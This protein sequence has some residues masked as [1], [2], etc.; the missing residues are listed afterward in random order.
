MQLLLASGMIFAGELAAKTLVV[1]SEQDYPPFA[2]GQNDAEADGFT[3]ELWK[4]VAKEAGLNYTIRVRPFHQILQEFKEG[5][6]D[7]L[8]NLAQ[9]DE[10]RQFVDFSIPHVTVNGAI[11][12]RKG[13]SSI[14]SEADFAGK[15]IIV[16]NADLAHDYAVSRGWSKQLVLTDKAADGFRLLSSGKHD[17]LLISKLTGMQTLR[18]LKISNIRAL[19]TKAG[20]SQKFSFAVHK[21]DAELLAKIN[22]GLALTKPSGVFDVL[23]ERWFGPYEEKEVTFLDVFKYLAPITFVLLCFAGYEF[24]KRQI[25]RRRSEAQ[26]ALSARVFKEA[27]EAIMITD[28]SGNIVDVNPTFSEITGYSRNEV[29]GQNPRMLSSGKH[30]P[31]FYAEMWDGL[32]KNGF[33]QSEVW[34]RKKNGEEFIEQLTISTLQ[35]EDNNVIHYVGL[36]SDIS[37]RKKMEIVL[38]D[39]ER[40]LSTLISTTPVGVFETD[41]DGKCTYVNDRWSEITGLQ[42][43][44]AQADGWAKAIHPEDRDTVFT[45]WAASVREERPF[46]LEYRFQ[47]ADGKVTW[48][49]GQSRDSRTASGELLGYIGTITD[50]SERKQAEEEL[51]MMRFCVDHAGDSIFWIDR[52]GRILYVNDAACSERGYSREELLA[53]SIFDLDPDYQQGVWGPHFEDLRQRI[54][55]TLETR[56]RTKSGHVYP[57]E[58]NANYVNIG[59]HEFN[60]AF[61]RDI[62][63][64]K[65]TEKILQHAKES[66][67]AHARSKSEFL[68]NMSHE[69]RTPMNGIIGLTE[70]ALNQQTSPEVRDYLSKIS[71]SSQSLLG[72]LNDILDFSKLEA[73]RM[74]IEHSQFHLDVVLDNLRNLFE[75]RA[76]AKHLDFSIAVAESTP[77]HLIGDAMRLQQILA[78]LLGNSIKFTSQGHVALRIS[79]SEIKD[80]L[81]HLHF[82]VEDTGIGISKDE[83]EKLFQPFS[84]ADTSI[85]RRFG[86]TGLGLAISHDMLELMGGKFEV[87]SVAGQGTSFSFDLLLDVAEIGKES[88]ERKRANRKEGALQHDLAEIGNRLHGAR[89]LVAEDN[90]INQQVVKEFLTLSGMEVTIANHGQEAID[91]LQTKSFDA[92]L[93]DISMPVMDGVQATQ[94]IRGK[95][96]YQKLP[97]IALTAGVTQEEHENCLACG[98]NDFVAKPINPEALIEILAKWIQPRVETDAPRVEHNND[99]SYIEDALP[100]FNLSTLKT[101][102]GGRADLLMGMLQSFFND[103]AGESTAIMSRIQKQEIPEAEK[104]L[105]RLKGAA[106][107]LGAQKL[108]QACETL[109]SQ[110]KKGDYNPDSLNKW[111]KVYDRTMVILAEALTKLEGRKAE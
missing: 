35:D 76:H 49:L 12:V 46:Q 72:I 19:E 51:Q 79:R 88:S 81:V 66:A 39:N 90:S 15:S 60:F 64:R 21:G 37:E 6:I 29:I 18:A 58:V 108:H 24:Y 111:L 86:G 10:R 5:K 34:N 14:H 80:S 62:T 42:L 59:G 25:E 20:F 71:S 26:L 96:Q 78:N 89:I 27:R 47:R 32:K 94:L 92:I 93:M 17:A 91:L 85:T 97:I 44:I 31:D 40:H 73:G 104:L 110:L 11:F 36:F 75:E 7:V 45:E 99:W 101:M 43:K 28:A 95:S 98:M 2:L 67:E 55:I 84:Q 82:V 106:G 9:S 63:S 109:D 83:Q 57:I 50:I 52:E 48:V 33:W 22:E 100:G 87:E 56:H 8:I 53:L 30:G 13:E 107:S 38:A 103:F 61:L 69:I 65:N 4:A 16:L 105:H 1:G 3:V 102:I 68:A 74:I 70:L 23:Y 54:T 77:R 41:Q